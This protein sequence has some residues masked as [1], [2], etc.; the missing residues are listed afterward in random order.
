M[1]ESGNKYNGFQ[2]QTETIA[3]MA[4]MKCML[5]I[6]KGIDGFEYDRF[7]RSYAAMWREI[8][9]PEYLASVIKTDTHALGYLRVNAIVQQFDEF[10][11][12]F[13]VKEGD[14]MYLA[15]EDR[16]LVW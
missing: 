12:T 10:Y 4:G 5:G 1:D 15:P 6:A 2:V 3:D 9:T 7:F 16:V 13:D 8:T 14:G 11:E